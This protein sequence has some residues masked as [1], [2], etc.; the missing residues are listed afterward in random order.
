MSKFSMTYVLVKQGRPKKTGFHNL[1]LHPFSWSPSCRFRFSAHKGLHSTPLQVQR[2]HYTIRALQ[3]WPSWTNFD[4]CVTGCYTVT[5][6]W[7][8]F[9]LNL[10]SVHL[11][12]VYL[13]API[14]FVAVY[15]NVHYDGYRRGKHH[16][17]KFR[18]S[19]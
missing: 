16:C 15:F 6:W 5:L 18:V 11:F 1:S 13:S 12:S 19:G 3:A 14:R 9:G 2:L 17:C 8:V 4:K 7:R 10:F